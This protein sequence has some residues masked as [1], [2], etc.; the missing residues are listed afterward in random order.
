M[1]RIRSV[2]HR[3]PHDRRAAPT[4]VRRPPRPRVPTWRRVVTVTLWTV[5]AV[6]SLAYATSLAVPI[7]FQV[8]GQRLLI[9]TSGSMS[10]TES[11]GFDAGD[12]VVMRKITDAS[13][14]KVGQVVSFVPPGSD[15]LVTHRIVSLHQLPVMQQDPTTGRMVE[16]LDPATGKTL[17]KPYII[18]QGDANSAP[19]VDA[20]PLTRVRGVVLT[21]YHEWGWVLQWAR[22]ADGRLAMLAPPLAA[23]VV[24]EVLSLVDAR[25]VRPEPPRERHPNEV[26]VDD[27]LL[28]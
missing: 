10:G 22:S 3:A 4:R 12:A 15:H 26:A 6:F 28:D 5:V 21:V 17:K 7:W 1:T 14:L 8:H 19:D 11:G 24:M 13:Q 27:L 9:V 16:T 25:R 18:T 2:L 23:L 20:T